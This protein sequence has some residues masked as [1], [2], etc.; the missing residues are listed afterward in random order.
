M[1]VQIISPERVEYEG[2]VRS[3][4]VPGEDG[5]I[6]ILAHHAP[7]LANLKAG[8]ITM[9]GANP[10]PRDRF[11]VLEGGFVEVHQNK[12]VVLAN[13]LVRKPIGA[14]SPSDHFTP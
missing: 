11:E 1:H 12:V 6:G 2:Q 14:G 9:S 8:S 5:F 10:Q 4:I 3:L 13:G 7:L